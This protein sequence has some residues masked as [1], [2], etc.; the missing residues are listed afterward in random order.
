MVEEVRLKEQYELE[1][2]AQE[3]GIGIATLFR[4]MVKK[5]II[6]VKIYRRTFIPGSE[7]ERLRKPA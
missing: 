2:A 7:I 5:K 1:E 4:W 6:S 3:L